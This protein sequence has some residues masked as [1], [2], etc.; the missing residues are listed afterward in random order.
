MELNAEAGSQVEMWV[1]GMYKLC[2]LILNG[3][4]GTWKSISSKETNYPAGLLG[5]TS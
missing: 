4:F 2:R 3:P 1:K 5:W